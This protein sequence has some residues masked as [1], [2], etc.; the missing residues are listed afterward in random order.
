VG[1]LVG[2]NI[3]TDFKINPNTTFNLPGA[4]PGQDGDVRADHVFD[5]GYVKIDKTGN[6]ADDDGVHWT[7]F[8][9]YDN[10]GQLSGNTLTYHSTSSFSTGGAGVSKSID[11]SPY[12]GVDVVYGGTICQWT[13][14]R[15]GWEAG[16]GWLPMDASSGK[17]NIGA[18]VVQSTYE[19]DTGG[20]VL[21]QAP[22]HGGNS[23]FGQPSIKDIANLIS[24]GTLTNSSVNSELELDV[25][26]WAFRLGP[27]FFW[28]V[29]PQI[30][31]TL[32]AG[33]AFGIVSGDLIFND[34]ITP[35][36]D[37]PGST[38]SNK[39]RIQETKLVYGGYVNAMVTYHAVPNGDFFVSAQYMP[40]TSTTFSG[41]GRSAKLD[42]S[43]AVF[44]SGGVNWPF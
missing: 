38:V 20:V 19:F 13:R 25:N 36:K 22:Y 33:P 8:W 41:G 43:G 5:D 11:D 39:G 35:D 12:I 29:T 10:G 18:S 31:L 4:K 37:V 15:F 44:I 26:L 32:A 28:D 7:T 9:G 17:Q 16:F 24:S 30:G 3:K 42:L 21:P 27:T 14:T 6:A 23:G 1:G 40:L 2:F 34:T